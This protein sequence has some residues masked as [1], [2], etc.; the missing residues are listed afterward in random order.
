MS[1]IAFAAAPSAIAAAA[2]LETGQ[3]GV[4]T[5]EA[6]GAAAAPM[7]WRSLLA[8]DEMER[9]LRMRAGHPREEF[10]AGRGTLR[11][12][13]GAALGRA[14]ESVVIGEGLHG[15]PC[16]DG[17]EFNVAHS[18][19]WVMIALCRDAAVGIDLERVQQGIETLDIARGSFATAE[20]A[21]L[22]RTPA[23][24][25]QVA[26]F[27][28][29]WTRKEAIVK[30]HGQGLTMPLAE[31]T[32]NLSLEGGEHRVQLKARGWP[33]DSD[34]QGQAFWVRGLDAP[35]GF[36]AATAVGRSGCSVEVHSVKA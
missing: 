15:K 9:Y 10:L 16:T 26:A 5:V 34:S 8:T 11:L 21:E 31:F 2:F 3:I 28:R 30:A 23:G 6:A 13:L 12:L 33:A 29:C 19:G 24:P 7:L 17:I 20:I 35:A 1:S 25:A 22:E 4:W 18:H 32:V 14:P 36:A 27:F